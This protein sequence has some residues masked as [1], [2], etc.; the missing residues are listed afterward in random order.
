MG[1]HTGLHADQTS[2]PS[3]KQRQK[4]T[5]AELATSNN[6]FVVIDAVNLND[7]LGEINAGCAKL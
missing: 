3:L 2:R 6:P 5:S 1:T 7:I 4:L